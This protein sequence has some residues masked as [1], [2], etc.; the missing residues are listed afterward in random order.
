MKSVGIRNFSG[1]NAGKSGPKN[2]KYG[3]F[4]SKN[5]DLKFM[6]GSQDLLRMIKKLP[7]I[8]LSNCGD[9]GCL[10]R[11]TGSKTNLLFRNSQN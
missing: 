2:S 8:E 6:K 11:K 1:A 5:H 3:Y 7:M 9:L 4:S 10:L